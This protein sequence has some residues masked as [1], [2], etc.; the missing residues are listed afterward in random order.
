MR[1][2]T[3]MPMVVCSE[4]VRSHFL[5]PTAQVS[6][7]WCWPQRMSPSDLW[8]EM[9][10]LCKRL[11]PVR[12]KRRSS[13]MRN[14]SRVQVSTAAPNHRLIARV[15]A[16]GRVIDTE[17]KCVAETF[18][19]EGDIK[20]DAKGVGAGAGRRI[21]GRRRCCPCH[22]HARCHDRGPTLFA[23]A[24]TDRFDLRVRRRS[25]HSRTSPQL[26]S[27]RCRLPPVHCLTVSLSLASPRRRCCLSAC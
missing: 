9:E 4:P 3:P 22:C 18:D 10:V 27:T 16:C 15:R 1:H 23:A 2:W 12:W 24:R 19:E 21:L 8:Y 26:L 11:A 7:C 14:A 5:K 17:I 6:D 20:A 13:V 25:P